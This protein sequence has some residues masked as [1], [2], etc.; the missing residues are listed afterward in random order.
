[1]SKMK[2][3]GNYAAENVRNELVKWDE[4]KSQINT[5]DI[6]EKCLLDTLEGATNMHELLLSIEDGIA[7][8]DGEIDYLKKR[9]EQL[10]I[11]QS[12]MKNTNESLRN[13]ITSVMDRAGIKTVTGPMAT[14]TV[15]STPRKLEIDDENII[16]SKFWI[17]QPPKLDKKMIAAA[18]KNKESVPGALLGNGGITLQIR[19]T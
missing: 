15:K 19:R 5:D 6:D 12:R 11:R 7:E 3:V 8:R 10:G 9:I 18:I 16:P 14:L 4:I 13:I 17:K 2:T 1:M